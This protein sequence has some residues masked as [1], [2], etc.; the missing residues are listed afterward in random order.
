M[1]RFVGKT[2]LITG[3]ARGI[4]LEISKH[5]A[6]EGARLFLFDINSDNLTQAETSLKTLVPELKIEVE[7]V[8]ISNRKAVIEAVERCDSRS[9]IDV[10][11]N[12][13]GIFLETSFLKIEE[14]EWRKILDV[15]LTGT[16]FMSQAVCR[17]MVERKKG[18]V[19]NMASKNGLYAESGYSHYDSSK[20]GIV[21][22]TK[23][24]SVELASFGIRTNAVA[25][26]YIETEMSKSIDSPEFV[27]DFVQRYIPMGRAGSV[28]DVAPMFLFLASD[29]SKFIN[30]QVFVIDGGQ[31]AGQKPSSELLNKLHSTS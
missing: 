30:G 9:P 16:F 1:R 24:M 20:G 14:D 18:V 5:F 13:A 25:P 27:K 21:M 2:V 11:I 8:D 31:I 3:G 19:V 29:E 7:V 15:N 6:R 28:E 26:G 22:L 10:L 4:G 12:N 23:T 17:K